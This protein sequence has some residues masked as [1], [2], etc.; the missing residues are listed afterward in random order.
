MTHRNPIHGPRD[1]GYIDLPSET[2]RHYW[3]R[4]FGC[5]QQQLADAVARVGPLVIDV[6]SHLGRRQ[7][8]DAV[9]NQIPTAPQGA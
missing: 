9:S 3:A 7:E 8:E 4:E 5:S 6:R 2:D 1:I